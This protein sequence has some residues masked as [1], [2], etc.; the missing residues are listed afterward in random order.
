MFG[1]IAKPAPYT[2]VRWRVVAADGD[3]IEVE[4]GFCMVC[5]TVCVVRERGDSSKRWMH[6]AMTTVSFFFD[7]KV[8]QPYTIFRVLRRGLELEPRKAN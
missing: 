6:T 3:P 2:A 5:G 4:G 8:L 1:H 7:T